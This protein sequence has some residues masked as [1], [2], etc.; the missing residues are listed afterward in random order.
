MPG[1]AGTVAWTHQLNDT[2]VGDVLRLDAVP[3]RPDLA[4]PVSAG[5]GDIASLTI[6]A[7]GIGVQED[8]FTVC[9]QDR[10]VGAAEALLWTAG[11]EEP[12][13]VSLPMEGGPDAAFVAVAAKSIEREEGAYDVSGPAHM[14]DLC[15]E[16][17]F[18][19]LGI[20][21]L[22]AAR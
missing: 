12:V 11:E 21:A 17:G 6:E 18:S 19:V 22:R 14:T 3:G 10:A 1:Q 15:L 20:P 2:V 16:R 5:G 4:Q 7:V 9:W 13:R 8:A